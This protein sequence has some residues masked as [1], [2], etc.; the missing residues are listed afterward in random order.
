MMLAPMRERERAAIEVVTGDA[1][2]VFA[3]ESLPSGGPTVT[4]L[5]PQPVLSRQHAS[6][7]HACGPYPCATIDVIS[8]GSP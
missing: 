5:T 4:T 2:C 3:K 6:I 7:A 8:C 1:S